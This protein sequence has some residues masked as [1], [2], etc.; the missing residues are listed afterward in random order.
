V[1]YAFEAALQRFR[2]ASDN[3][4]WM[5]ERS[6]ML[7]HLY[8]LRELCSQRHGKAAYSIEKNIAQLMA[9]RAACWARGADT[10]R[11]FSLASPS[12]APVSSDTYGAVC[13]KL[14]LAAG[15][16]PGLSRSLF[17]IGVVN[18]LEPFYC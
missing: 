6:N 10:N 3:D 18:P 11:L 1:R 15:L 4:A 7:H 2:I 8:R 17:Q 9:G 12:L 14:V 16:R 5:A 13:G